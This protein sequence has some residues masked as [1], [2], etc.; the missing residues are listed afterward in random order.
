M[1]HLW[2]VH[3]NRLNQ[4]ILDDPLYTFYPANLTTPRHNVFVPG[5]FRD[6]TE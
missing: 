3:V 2:T 5:L 1:E 6:S 4:K